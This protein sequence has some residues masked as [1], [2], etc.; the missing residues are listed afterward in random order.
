MP[1][2]VCNAVLADELWDPLRSNFFLFLLKA[3]LCSK[4]VPQFIRQYC[5]TNKNWHFLASMHLFSGLRVFLSLRE[6][7][8]ST[9]CIKCSKQVD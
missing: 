9:I 4:R 8:L 7:L 2:L 6:Y 5:I 1:V 3:S